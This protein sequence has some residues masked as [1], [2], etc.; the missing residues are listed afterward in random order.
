MLNV[1]TI[2]AT[3]GSGVSACKT[4]NGKVYFWGSAYGLNIS[5]PSPTRFRTIAE[6]FA[7]LDSPIMLEPVTFDLAQP[8]TEK[9]RSKLMSSF[10]SKV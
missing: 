2:G 7:S 4:A 8:F 5:K 3:R 6:V 1:T 10:D 9:L